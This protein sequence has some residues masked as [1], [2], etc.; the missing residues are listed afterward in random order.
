MGRREVCI[1]EG[2][3]NAL[4]LCSLGPGHVSKSFALKE[5]P[6]A[7]RNYDD[8]IGKIFNGEFSAA[9]LAAKEGQSHDR[10]RKRNGLGSGSSAGKRGGSEGAAARQG[11]GSP[12]GHSGNGSV[13]REGTLKR[14][15]Q[16]VSGTSSDKGGGGKNS[17]VQLSSGS[18]SR[19]I[20]PPSSSMRQ[21]NK[22]LTASG[23]F[24]KTNGYFRKKLRAQTTSEFSSS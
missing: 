9:A 4:R 3:C 15:F 17:K 24:R 5:C 8:V 13:S 21:K 10:N 18:P 1:F 11:K 16:D 14:K 6:K 23:S 19:V 7:M 2:Y 20:A 22:A 12:Y